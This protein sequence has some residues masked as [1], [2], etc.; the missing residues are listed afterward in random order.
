[1]GNWMYYISFMRMCDIAERISIVE[2][3]YHSKVLQELLQ[4]G[5]TSRRREEISE[6]LLSQPQ[7]F[8]NALVVGSFG[9]HPEWY[10]LDVR[11]R[12]SRMGPWPDHLDGTIGVLRLEGSEVLFAIDGQHRVAGISEA[13]R[14]KPE[15]AN[16]E[17]SVILVSGVIS[18][19]RDTDPE[20]FERTRRL[21]T[22]LNRYA[23]PVGKK[24]IIALDEDD[25]VAIVTRRLVEES[26]LLQRR[27]SVVGTKNMPT[28]DNE[29][30]TTIV[31]LY[32]ALDVYL[33]DRS[34]RAWQDYKK[35]RPNDE[36]VDALQLRS[37]ELFG[38]LSRSFP[39]MAEMSQAPVDV[40]WASQ[41]RHREG[42]HL[43]FRPIG[44]LIL[45]RAIRQLVDLDLS[46]DEAVQRIAQVPMD[47]SSHPWAGLLWDARNRRMIT[48]EV[49]QR[50]AVK[51]ILYGVGEDLSTGISESALV[52][53]LAGLLNA[54]EDSVRLNRYL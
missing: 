15:L 21:F 32:D 53:E 33:R 14:K 11:D 46:V 27:I 28:A 44:F 5:L 52:G 22:T 20:G 48:A 1:M 18:D 16:E 45:T 12:H 19:Q 25:V 17:V 26:P 47:L 29:N 6:Y 23:K 10:E 4:R 9:G 36:D 41:Y 49:N 43:L 35:W 37:L 40:A 50:A 42:G 7:R 39:P 24:D 34:A 38:A 31:T 8:F 51:I 3:I 30:F 13:I 54:S 2:D